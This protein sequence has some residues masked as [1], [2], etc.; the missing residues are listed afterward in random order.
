MKSFIFWDISSAL[1]AT[2]FNAD[3]LLGLFF[4]LEEE[5]DIF[6]RNVS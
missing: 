6:L 4:D 1:L 5:G 2:C 3:L